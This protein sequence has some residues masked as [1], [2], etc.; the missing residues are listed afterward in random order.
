M[1]ASVW[2]MLCAL[3]CALFVVPLV[4]GFTG[5]CSGMLECATGAVPMKCH[6]A[7]RAEVLLAPLGIVAMLLGLYARTK[8]GRRIAVGLSAL[9]AVA[10]ALMLTPLGIGICA[11][12]EMSCNGSAM[13]L[14]AACAA[15]VVLDAVL[16]AKADPNAVAKP[17]RGL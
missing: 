6:W 10:S 5:A 8:E 12:A 15:L 4:L 1:K 3:G 7:F 13:A 2:K 9:V 14:W 11:S 17:K 16:L